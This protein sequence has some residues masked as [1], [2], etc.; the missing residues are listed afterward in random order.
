MHKENRSSALDVN[1][2]GISYFFF[3][4]T[5]IHIHTNMKPNTNMKSN[6]PLTTDILKNYCQMLLPPSDREQRYCGVN[7]P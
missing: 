2:S 7:D 6:L 3:P 5:E 1:D 4:S